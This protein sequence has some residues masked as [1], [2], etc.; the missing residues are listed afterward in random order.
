MADTVPYYFP[1]LTAHT[2]Y[3]KYRALDDIL[4]YVSQVQQTLK[5]TVHSR[6]LTETKIT[7]QIYNE[8]E[9]HV[10]FEVNLLNEAGFYLFICVFQMDRW[11]I[12]C[13]PCLVSD[14]QLTATFIKALVRLTETIA[15]E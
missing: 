9:I 7:T 12:F 10:K 2:V 3:G 8:F 13:F 14:L 5:K 11:F 15:N 6:R 4:L 1:K